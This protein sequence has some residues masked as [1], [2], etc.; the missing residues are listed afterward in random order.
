MKIVFF[1]GG[2]ANQVFQ[3]IFYRYGQISSPEE[4]WYLDDSFFFAHKIHNG[5][6]LERVFGIRPNL[7]SEYFDTEVWEY[8][9]DLKINQNESI[10]QILVENDAAI[11]MISETS[12]W[13]EW[14]P[15]DGE[16]TLL[17]KQHSYDSSIVRLPGDIYYHGY[18]I[19]N[20]W[21]KA[22]EPTIRAELTFPEIEKTDN[23]NN[24]YLKEI[25]Q[26]RSC[27]IHIRRGDF[28]DMG[29][30]ITDEMCVTHVK[31]VLQNVPDLT[32]FVFSDDLPYCRAHSHEMGL[33][34]PERTVYVEGNSGERAFRDL[35]LMSECK[36]M[37]N[38]N[39]SFCY[40][41]ALLNRDRWGIFNAST[42][43]L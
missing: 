40:L 23:V 2:L 5:Y 26:T 42:Y 39:S 13:S 8:M 12:N 15:F 19:T 16:K 25:R 6:E 31:T 37:I 18:W 29:I 22:I 34:L 11:R 35:Q 43:K 21:F 30:A 17:Y 24:E 28:A 7:L 32:L 36:Y 10:P 33:D 41:A 4:D 27:S 1:N 14:N 3:Y 9:I 38:G 20:D